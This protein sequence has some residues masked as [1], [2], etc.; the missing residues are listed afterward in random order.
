ML[1]QSYGKAEF[2]NDLLSLAKGD[3]KLSQHS[4]PGSDLS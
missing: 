2:E 4:Q 3:Y 1:Q